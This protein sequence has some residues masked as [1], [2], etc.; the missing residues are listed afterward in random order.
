MHHSRRIPGPMLPPTIFN[1]FPC[2]SRHTTPTA[3][4]NP[5]IPIFN[6]DDPPFFS[7]DLIFMN[8]EFTFLIRDTSF[9]FPASWLDHKGIKC[10]HPRFERA[11]IFNHYIRGLLL[12]SSDTSPNIQTLKRDFLNLDNNAR[13]P[14][15][16]S[17]CGPCMP[18]APLV[19]FLIGFQS[20][21]IHSQN[22]NRY[23]FWPERT[24]RS[25]Q[26]PNIAQ[27]SPI[28]SLKTFQRTPKNPSFGRYNFHDRIIL[29]LK[30]VSWVACSP[31]I[32]QPKSI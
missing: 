7:A 27:C 24:F 11:P 31:P 10:F 18:C 23:N 3:I 32:G 12:L 26:T 20:S 5:C 4:L 28:F 19:P 30:F 9:Q 13:Q 1:P 25:F 15:L 17:L 8:V 16:K 6:L 14:T 21:V 29:L 2:G 22:Y